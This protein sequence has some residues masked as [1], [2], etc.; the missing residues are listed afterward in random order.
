MS[1]IFMQGPYTARSFLCPKQEIESKYV[2]GLCIFSPPIQ[3]TTSQG[4][5]CSEASNLRRHCKNLLSNQDKEYFKNIKI[6]RRVYDEQNIKIL[7]K[8]RISIIV[9]FC[10]TLQYG[11]IS[12]HLV[13][14]TSFVKLASS[15]FFFSCW[16]R[17]R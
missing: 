9:S 17:C 8:D 2:S 6:M 4:Q 3:A 5:D 1:D 7:N 16:F 12:K 11:L 15:Q 13:C 14:C 10:F